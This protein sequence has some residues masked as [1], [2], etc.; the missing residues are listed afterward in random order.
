M[1][2]TWCSPIAPTSSREIG[3]DM[4]YLEHTV[5][6]ESPSSKSGSPNALKC[7]ALDQARQ[8][9]AGRGFFRR[10]GR[11]QDGDVHVQGQKTGEYHDV[12]SVSNLLGH[13]TVRTT[14]DVYAHLM[15]D[16][17]KRI[18]QAMSP[19][20]PVMARLPLGILFNQMASWG[21]STPLFMGA[22]PLARVPNIC[23]LVS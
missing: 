20:V 19:E 13:K 8:V 9:E 16:A 5:P 1:P 3:A 23:G 10:N 14:Q 11:S 6:Y 2:V 15:D 21:C 4:P 22:G 17:S 12:A 18:G 7:R